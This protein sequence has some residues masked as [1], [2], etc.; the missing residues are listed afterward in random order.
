MDAAL[1]QHF[2]PSPLTCRRLAPLPFIAGVVVGV[3]LILW[4]D[5]TRK[6]RQASC[7]EARFGG[8]RARPPQTKVSEDPNFTQ[9]LAAA[10][11]SKCVT[12]AVA[13]RQGG[14]CAR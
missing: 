8:F 3:A 1:H 9:A 12:K 2:L 14:D 7:R 6:A 13:Y 4:K 11:Q 10:K 5:R